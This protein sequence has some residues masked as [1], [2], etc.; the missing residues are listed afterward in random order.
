LD[1]VQ[2]GLAAEGFCG[3]KAHRLEV[4]SPVGALLDFS[5]AFLSFPFDYPPFRVIDP[6]KRLDQNWT[7]RIFS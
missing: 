7:D 2:N 3:V 4:L 1:G 5:K 6:A